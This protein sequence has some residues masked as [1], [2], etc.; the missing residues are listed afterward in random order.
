[1][2]SSA[3]TERSSALYRPSELD[4][5]LS[6]WGICVSDMG[7]F[8]CSAARLGDFTLSSTIAR[9]LGPGIMISK[10]SILLIANLGRV[11]SRFGRLIQ[12]RMP[13]CSSIPTST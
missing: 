8:A 10:V 13:V 7:I 9:R 3:A 11:Y 1:M 5:V 12:G 4:Y 2:F 6:G